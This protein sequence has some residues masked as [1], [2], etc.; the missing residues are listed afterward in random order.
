MNKC[1]AKILCLT[2]SVRRMEFRSHNNHSLCKQRMS[3]SKIELWN[4]TILIFG[5]ILDLVFISRNL[6]LFM[7]TSK[8]RTS[9]REESEALTHVQDAAIRVRDA[10]QGV[11]ETI[12]AV[13]ESGVIKEV[14][15]VVIEGAEAARDTSMEIRDAAVNINQSGVIDETRAA[16]KETMEQLPKLTPSQK[17]MIRAGVQK[18]K[19]GA[20]NAA[21]STRK[22]ISQRISKSK[23]KARHTKKKTRRNARRK[24]ASNHNRSRS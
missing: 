11:R 14:G 1:L 13:R 6:L 22:S 15:G 23:S 18:A 20:L 5:I 3:Y 24:T 12:R 7:A 16:A 21:R 10:A 19:R 9:S 4:T 17:R 2:E 8:R